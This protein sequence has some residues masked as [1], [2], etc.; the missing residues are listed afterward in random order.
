M[1]AIYLDNQSSTPVDPAVLRAMLP[2]LSTS[3]GNPH[4][5][6]HALGW[7]AR[8]AVEAARAQ[9]AR[10]IGAEQDEIVFTSGATEAN[11]LALLGAAQALPHRTKV[12][13]A[14]IE[15]ASVLGPA[16][17][18]A[19]RGFEVISLPV[20]GL[21][22]VD[23]ASANAAVDEST[24][25]F[26]LGAVNGEI[27]VIA[28]L[29]HF[30][31]LCLRKGALFHVDAAQALTAVSLDVSCVPI[32]LLS[33]SAHKAYGP[34]GI[35]ALYVSERAR[36]RIVPV[37]FG[38]GQQGGLR[39]G[40]TPVALAV[41]FGTACDLVKSRGE[42]ERRSIAAL[43]D[44]L[45]CSLTAA[46]PGLALNGDAARRHPGNLNIRLPGVDARE[47]VQRLQPHLACSTGSA[48]NSGSEDPSHVIT[49]L[50]LSRSEALSSLRLSVGRFVTVNEIDEATKMII[51]AFEA[52][53]R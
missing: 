36:H 19:D 11:N 44:R 49:A 13:V 14:A 39:S 51:S 52:A 40:T 2:W 48:C 20:D 37:N 4:S 18:L 3:F 38:G 9:V 45:F 50:G 21:G 43:R 34:Q 46:I 24:L 17:E 26:S 31:D 15:H 47:V 35:G 5:S 33:L 12:V 30:A 25:I 22:H 32:D 28:N 8:A 42:D 10:I 23:M 53:Q 7:A 29:S 41:G 16:R 27:G 6:E 1:S